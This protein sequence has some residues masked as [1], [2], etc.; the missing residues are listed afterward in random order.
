MLRHFKTIWQV[1]SIY[2]IHRSLALVFG[3]LVDVVKVIVFILLFPAAALW[4]HDWVGL[5]V[6]R[7][8]LHI[9]VIVLTIDNLVCLLFYFVPLFRSL[10]LRF[11]SSLFFYAFLVQVG[12]VRHYF[13]I[14]QVNN[15]NETEGT[16]P[17]QGIYE[18]HG[19]AVIL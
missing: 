18:K 13:A 9:S 19:V 3:L 2:L 17:E 6:L 12:V 14:V 10:F 5:F 8:R 16:Q 7:S 11:L 1:H 4:H 15:D